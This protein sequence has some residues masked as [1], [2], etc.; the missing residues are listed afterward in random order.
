MPFAAAD[1][2]RR[3]KTLSRAM[4]KHVAE[5]LGPGYDGAI[6]ETGKGSVGRQKRYMEN[7][8][9]S[10]KTT[11]FDAARDAILDEVAA[12]PPAI[13]AVLKEPLQNL[14]FQ[15][16]MTASNLWENTRKDGPQRAARASLL[17]CSNSIQ[18]QI[19]LWAAAAQK[20][21]QE[22]KAAVHAY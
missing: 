15:I 18:G 5:G 7:F 14:A 17:T 2:G 13:G 4:K 22:M 6:L 9:D 19:E 10:H 21:E 3:A 11:I 20:K 8:V 1:L 12:I 16:E